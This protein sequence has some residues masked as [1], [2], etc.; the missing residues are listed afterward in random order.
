MN[1]LNLYKFKLKLAKDNILFKF[2]YKLGN[3][4]LEDLLNHINKSKIDIQA[5]HIIIDINDTII[6]KKDKLLKKNKE[7]PCILKIIKNI[8][9]SDIITNYIT[10][11]KKKNNFVNLN[12]EFNNIKHDIIE[13]DNNQHNN[14]IKILLYMLL[15]PNIKF[16]YISNTNNLELINM[17]I[18]M[19]KNNNLINKKNYLFLLQQNY[20]L[21]NNKII[22]KFPYIGNRLK[23]NNFDTFNNSLITSKDKIYLYNN[24][25]ELLYNLFKQNIISKKRLKFISNHLIKEINKYTKENK[26]IFY[27]EY[28]YNEY[29]DNLKKSLKKI[30]NLYS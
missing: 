21:H 7:Y 17:I 27:N 15:F 28:T 9:K 23:E 25:S 11:V 16:I 10:I 20:N 30:D 1:G 19:N 8:L 6:S 29:F 3:D 5:Y 14:T 22:Y 13:I 12:Y 18:N 24:Y 2:I 4:L 26:Y